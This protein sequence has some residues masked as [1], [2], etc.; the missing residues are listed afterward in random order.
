M[1][2]DTTSG[3]HDGEP[4]AA[5]PGAAAPSGTS[6]A[7]DTEVFSILER[8]LERQNTTL[9]LIASENFTSRA[10]MAATGSS[11]EELESLALASQGVQAHI[12][13]GQVAKVI[14]VPDKLVNVV[15][16]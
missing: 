7:G 10:V 16:R 11:R 1:S 8:E 15:V 6:G 4:A 14:V 13:G 2:D 3:R 9:Q 5:A 12:N